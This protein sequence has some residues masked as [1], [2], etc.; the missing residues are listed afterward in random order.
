MLLANAGGAALFGL[1]ILAALYFTPTIV[2][3]VRN[4]PDFGSV[5]VLNLFL[6][7][8]VIFWVIALA[9]ASR[10]AQARRAR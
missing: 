10:S 2:A 3:K 9:M 8:T 1:L 7:W 5:F 4:V 6:G